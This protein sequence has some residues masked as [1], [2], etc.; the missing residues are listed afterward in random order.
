MKSLTAFSNE[1]GRSSQYVRKHAQ[2]LINEH[3]MKEGIDFKTFDTPHD[4]KLSLTESG[5]QKIKQEI[6]KG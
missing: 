6:K 1:M 4:R 3:R 5:E 2:R